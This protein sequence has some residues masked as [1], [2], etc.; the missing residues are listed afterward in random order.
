M[1]DQ[2]RFNICNL[3]SS[4]VPDKEVE[5]MEERIKANISP[6]L[7]YACRF[8]TSHLALAPHASVL[9]LLDE[10]LR[11]RLL[12]WMEVL[13][14]RREL[15]TGIE[16]LLKVQQWLARAEP[17][18]SELMYY[19][20]DARSFV[21]SFAVNPT[22]QSTPHI[23]LS[24]LS[25]CPRSNTVYHHGQ[26][27]RGLL[28]LKGSLMDLRE[29]APLAVWDIGSEHVESLALSP[30]GNRV[31]TGCS[32]KMLRILSA[33]DG[34]TQLGPLKGHTEAV[35]SIAFSPDGGRVVS[36]S[37]HD[38]IV[39]NA[40]NGTLI[41]GPFRSSQLGTILS[42][43]F[44]PDGSLLVSGGLDHTVRVWNA[45]D[46]S[47]LFDPLASGLDLV[48]CTKFS[49]NGSLIAAPSA[50]HSIRLW[51]TFDGSPS[52]PMLEGH[53]GPVQSFAFTP[54]ST[55]LVSGSNDQTIRV[56]NISDGSLVV[57]PFQGHTSAIRAVDVSH[58]GTRVVSSDSS[59]IRLW[60]IDDGT[61][62]AGPFYAI[63]ASPGS[64]AFSPDDTR[65]IYA[66]H[67][68]IYVRSMR[69]G[70][71]LRAP[72]TLQDDVII[73]ISSV[74]FRSEG[75]H[76]MT[77]G[78]AGALRIWNATDGSFTTSPNKAEFVQSSFSTL[79]PDGSYI[80]GTQGDTSLQVVDTMDGSLAAGPFEIER[81]ELS[82]LSF[83]RNN[84]A[85]I[86]GFLDGTIKLCDLKSGNTTV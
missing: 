34:T 63:T 60:N 74:A 5:D 76:F 73:G 58:D 31:A 46:G 20:D 81:S 19:V 57:D 55:R 52:G 48:F 64:L 42:V 8:W 85:I 80:A 26:R 83:S 77:S 56:W 69:D 33:Y 10:F 47:P 37:D 41:T 23:Y 53:T 43:S 61:L 3:A 21:T 36:S 4:F 86:M 30:D 82:T 39:W 17:S 13:S 78:R 62:V 84:R 38:I 24:S 1:K 49:P 25:L 71:F 16:G 44:S 15:A 2:L 75:T 32:D 9:T 50:D 59:T 68:R 51:N 54:D 27:L 11:D 35:S 12:F 66:G 70:M 79:S 65:I 28:E 18:S 45:H 29:G 72:A 7:A 40:Y 67:G 14:L 6:T 22:S